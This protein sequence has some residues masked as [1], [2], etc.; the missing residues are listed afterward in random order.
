MAVSA[1]TKKGENP[2]HLT[3]RAARKA[4]VDARQGKKDEISA[5]T[6]SQLSAPEKDKLLQLLGEQTG[7]ILEE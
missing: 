2:N 5:K 3:E 7:L 6:F 1:R 4:V